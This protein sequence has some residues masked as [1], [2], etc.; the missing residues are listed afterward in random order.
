MKELSYRNTIVQLD[1]EQSTTLFSSF[2]LHLF[3]L[4]GSV[5]PEI[6]FFHFLM[7][8]LR[9]AWVSKTYLS[10]AKAIKV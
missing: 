8:P 6:T 9:T 1:M 2:R 5:Y 7:V 10:E 3:S 4:V